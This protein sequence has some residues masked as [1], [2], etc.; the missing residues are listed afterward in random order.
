M[1]NNPVVIRAAITTKK[2]HPDWE[3]KLVC[4]II[5]WQNFVRNGRYFCY[6][7]I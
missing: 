3:V 1:N 6:P 2:N 4:S 5:C 7:E